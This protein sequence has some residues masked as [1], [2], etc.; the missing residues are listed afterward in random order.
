MTR[1]HQSSRA[2]LA[3]RARRQLGTTLRVADWSSASP[4]CPNAQRCRIHKIRN[5]TERLPKDKA[6]QVR[7]VMTQSF[8]LDAVR[9]KSKLRE[10]AR[11][12]RAQH[13]DAGASGKP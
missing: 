13:P 4:P 12:L 8:K 10:L 6:Q 9:G 2:R 3:G 5:V 1:R 7:R 11:Q